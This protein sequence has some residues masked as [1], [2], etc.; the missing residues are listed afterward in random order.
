MNT[1]LWIMVFIFSSAIFISNIIGWNKS[2]DKCEKTT[3]DK[4]V[5]YI[6]QISSIFISLMSIYMFYVIYTG[7]KDEY[8][9]PMK[10]AFGG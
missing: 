7:A 8:T 9:P 6:T 4:F 5:Y 1:I 3:N 10:F 2:K